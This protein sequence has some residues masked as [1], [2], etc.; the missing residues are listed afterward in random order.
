MSEFIRLSDV[1]EPSSLLQLVR[2][3]SQ[4]TTDRSNTTSLL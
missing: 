2:G 3:H 4:G 1:C